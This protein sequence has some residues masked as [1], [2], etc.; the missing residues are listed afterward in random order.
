MKEI[1]LKFGKAF[2][3][4]G[5]SGVAVSLALGVRISSL[6]DLKGVLTVLGVA[7]LSGAVHATIEALRPTLPATTSSVVT[8]TLPTPQ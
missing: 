3:T 6:D 8:T 1:L 7:F 4:G 2:L 5:L